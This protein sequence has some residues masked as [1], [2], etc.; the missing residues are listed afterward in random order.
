MRIPALCSDKTRI[1]ISA[2]PIGCTNDVPGEHSVTG[3]RVNETIAMRML[4]FKHKKAGHI[5]VLMISILDNDW[6]VR[7]S[8]STRTI[9]ALCRYGAKPT[10]LM[11]RCTFEKEVSVMRCALSLFCRQM[12]VCTAS[13]M[14]GMTGRLAQ[15]VERPLCMREVG[16]STPPVSTLCK[17]AS[18]VMARLCCLRI[19][20]SFHVLYNQT[21]VIVCCFRV[22]QG[23]ELSLDSRSS[24]A[25]DVPGEHPRVFV[26]A[27]SMQFLCCV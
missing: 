14:N 21:S 8:S 16:G 22:A 19:S 20:V 1:S 15:M 13:T 17:R 5:D 27:F 6:I 25:D 10:H 11:H 18:V 4:A 3:L 7:S 24:C 2:A 26:R 12:S 23:A 9:L